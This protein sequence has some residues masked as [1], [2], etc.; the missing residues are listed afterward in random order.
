[1]KN[2]F[3]IL[4][5]VLIYNTASFGQCNGFAK[6]SVSKLKPYLNTQQVFSTVLLNGDKTQLSSTFYYGDEYRLL[7]SAQDQLGKIQLNIKDVNGNVVFT[8]KAYGTIMWDFNVEST[9]D[10]TLEVIT[11]P[12]PATQTE[13]KSGCVSIIIGFK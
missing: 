11:P 4:L 8:T 13:D 6:K 10:L 1:M 9:Q 7:I 3:R 12:A 2:I 5:L